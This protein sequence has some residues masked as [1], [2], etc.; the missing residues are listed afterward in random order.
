MCRYSVGDVVNVGIR[1]GFRYQG[2]LKTQ[3]II[4]EIQHGMIYA[5]VKL[6]AGAYKKMFGYEKDLIEL[7]NNYNEWNADKEGVVS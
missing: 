1:C 5:K 6:S 4:T 3:A 7:E 2:K